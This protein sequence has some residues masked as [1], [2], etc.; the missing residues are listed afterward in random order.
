MSKTKKI[1]DP[2]LKRKTSKYFTYGAFQLSLFIKKVNKITTIIIIIVFINPL[3]H[4]IPYMTH[5]AKIL[6]LRRNRQKKKIVR[7]SRL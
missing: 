3:L 6:I 4:S 1:T 5:S 2:S 7:A